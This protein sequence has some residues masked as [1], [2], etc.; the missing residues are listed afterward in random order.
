MK[1]RAAI[2]VQTGQ[3]LVIGELEIP[4]LKPAQVLVEICY[5]GACGTQLLEVRGRRGEDKWVPH[6]LGHEGTGVVLEVGADVRKVKPG[7]AV[8]L[9]WIKGSGGEAGG[10]V[11]RWDGRSVNAGGVTTFQRH[12]VVS[13][14]RLTPLPAG[15]SMELAVL[16]GCAA[17]TGMGSIVNV[18]KVQPGEAVAV[19]GVGGVG[20][21][22]CLAARASG[23]DPVIAV[24][25]S[26]VRRDFAMRFG[27]TLAIDP[28]DTDVATAIRAAAPKGLDVAI[29]AA[30]IPAVTAQALTLVRQQGG[31]TV[32]I[33]N[34]PHGQML[35]ID[36]SQ[37][38]QGKS[39]LGTWGGDAQ[40]DRDIPRFARMVTDGR[41]PSEDLLSAPYSLDA[42]DQAL[43]DLEAGRIGRPLID[44]SLA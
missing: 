11:Y 19:F 42:I 23:A 17:P 34:A 32:V 1:T 40:P 39:L 29:E 14:N 31:R 5:S 26:P 7:D 12:A 24:D 36:P 20:L 25:P 33:G 3:P 18:A 27:A 4:A 13:E 6:C 15:T 43:D 10:T 28:A 9:S 30:G 8:V 37:F 38:N 44:M 21:S 2:L 41:F 35:T 16:L 22:A